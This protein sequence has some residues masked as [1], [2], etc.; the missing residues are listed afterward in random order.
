MDQPIGSDRSAVQQEARGKPARRLSLLL[1]SQGEGGVWRG[2]LELATALAGENVDVHVAIPAPTTAGQRAAIARAGARIA[3]WDGRAAS[4]PRL[5]REAGADL[6]HLPSPALAAEIQ[7]PV[8]VVATLHSCPAVR[9][10]SIG[11]GPP[12]PAVAEE[13]AKIRAGIDRLDLLVTPT[14]AFAAAAAKVHGLSAP[15]A[16]VH[17][18]RA[19]REAPSA[20][21]HDF[22]F[23]SSLAWDETRDLATLERAA[24]RLAVPLYAAGAIRAADAQ[25]LDHVHPL[26]LLDH[27]E[28]DRRLGARPVFVSA[29][30]YEPFGMT[31]LEAAMAGCPLVL[32]DIPTHRELW[33]GVASFAPP[34]DDAAFARAISEL[35]GDDFARAARGRAA[36][37]RA[38]NYTSTATASRMA[39]LYRRLA[40][41]R[42]MPDPEP[43]PE[44]R[45]IAA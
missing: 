12:P 32:S 5:A 24:A 22:A 44:L 7:L 41:A 26:G 45:T 35:V 6:V 10:A 17:H 34:G 18:G 23:A 14:A 25:G 37:E 39:A 16:T 19:W 15:P 38:R 11:E 3:A 27:E 1:V 40:E 43:G 33:D 30:R 31:V 9:W 21:P 2:G 28:I 8:P 36:R 20:A 4:L 13:A 29:A 42:P